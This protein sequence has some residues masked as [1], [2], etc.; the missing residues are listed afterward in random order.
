MNIFFSST[1]IFKS[2][3]FV[4]MFAV[5]VDLISVS[6]DRNKAAHTQ[7]VCGSEQVNFLKKK[8]KMQLR[9]VAYYA[10]VSVY[11][12]IFLFIWDNI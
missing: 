9:A 4:V 5:K 6:H 8:K 10:F 7:A 12:C 1:V 2:P 3:W 11:A